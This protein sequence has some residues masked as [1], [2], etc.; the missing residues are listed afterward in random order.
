MRSDS[1]RDFRRSQQNSMRIHC[2][3]GM[4]DRWRSE[5]RSGPLTD[6]AS[7]LHRLA[8]EV[9]HVRPWWSYMGGAS[10]AVMGYIVANIPGAVAGGESAP[11]QLRRKII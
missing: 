3:L 8:P 4:S 6:T 5:K 1:I 10:G 11:L 9:A 7:L 2:V